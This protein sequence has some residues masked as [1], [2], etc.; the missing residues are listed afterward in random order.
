M[1]KGP[2]VAVLGGY[3][4]A[5]TLHQHLQTNHQSSV[6]IQPPE[7]ADVRSHALQF[8]ETR[9]QPLH[10]AQEQRNCPRR[11]IGRKLTISSR[12][13]SAEQAFDLQE[14]NIRHFR[15]KL[16]NLVGQFKHI[17]QFECQSD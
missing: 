16:K 2:N 6:V 14:L 10:I 15:G 9:K 7:K 3:F 12:F 8:F 17:A 11:I 5:R 13:V 1:N 4:R